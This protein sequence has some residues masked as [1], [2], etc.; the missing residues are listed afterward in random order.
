MVFRLGSGRMELSSAVGG[1]EFSVVTLSLRC[2]SG[3]SVSCW[4]GE[5]EFRGGGL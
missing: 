1:A 5:A 3:A 4:L 2:A